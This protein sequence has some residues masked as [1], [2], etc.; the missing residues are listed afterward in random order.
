MNRFGPE[1]LYVLDEPEAGL[2]PRSC[3]ALLARMHDLV[4]EGSQF[5][6]ATHSPMLLAY[7]GALIYE[8]DE[9]GSR[10]SPSRTPTSCASLATS[11]THPSGTSD[12]SSNDLGRGCV[13]LRHNPKRKAQPSAGHLL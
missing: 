2:S 6:V 10:R 3:L 5:V 9:D 1:G 12:T 4:G 11:W 8:L 7:P 13:A